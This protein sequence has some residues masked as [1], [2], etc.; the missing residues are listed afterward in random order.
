MT[1]DPG[2]IILEFEVVLGRRGE[3]VSG[4][5][6]R[7]LVFGIKVG[8][9]EFPINL[10]V[11]A[12]DGEADASEHVVGRDPVSVA[13]IDFSSDDDTLIVLVPLSLA[14]PLLFD[15]LSPAGGIFILGK[16]VEV[17][18]GVDGARRA[19][20]K[21]RRPS[22]FA[23]GVWRKATGGCKHSIIGGGGGGRGWAIFGCPR[24]RLGNF[25]RVTLD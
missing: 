16:L 19:A 15:V 14:R 1:E 12:A 3:F 11:C 13:L 24:R 8:I 18:V 4:D 17:G 21:L 7:E 6:E 2:C 22:T 20:Y 23:R 5:I 25:K 9:V 10:C